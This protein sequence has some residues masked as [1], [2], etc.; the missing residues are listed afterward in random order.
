M[1]PIPKNTGVCLWRS[2]DCVAGNREGLIGITDVEVIAVE[3][4]AFGSEFAEKAVS[5][6]FREYVRLVDSRSRK[7][8][9]EL[10]HRQLKRETPGS[11]VETRRVTVSIAHSARSENL[12][13]VVTH[14]S[15]LLTS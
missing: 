14:D 10:Q 1:E 4:T 5:I 7:P 6:Q 15:S 12:I 13:R 9:I 2:S 11:R 3:G 8:H